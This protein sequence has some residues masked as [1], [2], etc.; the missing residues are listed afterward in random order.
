[1]PEQPTAWLGYISVASL[2][3]TVAKVKAKGGK[4]L[5]ERMEIPGMGAFSMFFDPTGAAL[6]AWQSAK[7]AA[8]EARKAVAKKVAPKPKAV[9]KKV[10]PKPKAVAKKVAPKP[11]A[12][13]N[14]KK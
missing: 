6:A 11:K 2:A 3:A 5:V 4:V 9:A 14:K 12:V 10:A 1:M 7:S 8:V 13:K